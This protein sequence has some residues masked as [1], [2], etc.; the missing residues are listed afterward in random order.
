MD[1][2]WRDI[3]GYEGLY[4]I[5][6][7]GRVWSVKRQIY[8]KQNIVNSY[9]QLSLVC[10]NGKQKSEKV[11]RLVALT[12]L[13]EPP[14]GKT[15]VNHKDENK[16]NNC[17]ENLEWCDST[18]NNNYGGRKEKCSKAMINNAKK[19][20]PIHQYDLQGNLIATYPSGAEVE[21][22]LGYSRS[23]IYKCAKGTYLTAYGYVWRYAE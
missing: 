12:F 1:E 23:N 14:E 9:Y 5:S 20:K 17:V 21:R 19:S 16:L 4:Q 2:I 6:N 22:V 15:V 13:G 3:K 18:Y 8:M 7:K 11:H 10:K